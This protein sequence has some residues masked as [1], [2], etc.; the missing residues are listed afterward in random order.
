MIAKLYA[1]SLSSIFSR[2][3]HTYTHTIFKGNQDHNIT[4]LSSP[5]TLR[6]PYLSPI[7]SRTPHLSHIT[8]RTPHLTLITSQTPS[9]TIF[10]PKITKKN[11][12]EKAF[13]LLSLENWRKIMYCN[14]IFSHFLLYTIIGCTSC[15]ITFTLK[16]FRSFLVH[17]QALRLI[18]MNIPLPCY[19]SALELGKEDYKESI[20][21][22]NEKLL[23]GS[24]MTRSIFKAPWIL[25]S[26]SG[27][28]PLTTILSRHRE[29][30]HHPDWPS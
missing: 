7:A 10:L 15:H 18:K 16:V 17:S 13:Y 9:Y 26:Q 21:H 23:E 1:N 24:S 5:V 25:W 14:H 6:I 8:Y 27:L 3:T 28:S 12:K 29:R 22:N 4:S 30:H 19:N 2:H 20:H 11:I